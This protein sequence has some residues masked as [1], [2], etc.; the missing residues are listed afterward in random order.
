M[1]AR[2]GAPAALTS[3]WGVSASGRLVAGGEYSAWRR[4]S[5]AGDTPPR[6]AMAMRPKLLPRAAAQLRHGRGD[7]LVQAGGFAGGVADAASAGPGEGGAL[8]DRVLPQARAD[9]FCYKA[10]NQA[11]RRGPQD[12]EGFLFVS[13]SRVQSQPWAPGPLP[14]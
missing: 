3:A 7:K 2:A 4:P 10:E 12:V 1:R 9:S 13:D 11:R 5:L 6:A 8:G 14:K